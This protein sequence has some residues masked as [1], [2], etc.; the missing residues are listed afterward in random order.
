M[1]Y[2]LPIRSATT[3]ETAWLGAT[4]TVLDYAARVVTD[5]VD[6]QSR[7]HGG[8]D[9]TCPSSAPSSSPPAPSTTAPYLGSSPGAVVK[10]RGALELLERLARFVP[11]P[12]VHRHR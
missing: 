4:R 10:P 11:P 5:L 12:R 8:R 7:V 9:S 6:S 2:A 1:G 3:P